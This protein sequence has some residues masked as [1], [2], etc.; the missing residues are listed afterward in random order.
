MS[1]RWWEEA[2]E[3]EEQLEREK[4]RAILRLLFFGKGDG[5]AAALSLFRLSNLA[6]SI[7]R[8]KRN[9][10]KHDDKKYVCV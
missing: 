6:G 4:C 2:L 10:H 5:E 1:R 9:K 8:V 7:W 3:E